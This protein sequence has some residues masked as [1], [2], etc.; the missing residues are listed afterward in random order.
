MSLKTRWKIETN[1][2]IVYPYGLMYILSAVLAI[3]FTVLLV[4]YIKYE[5]AVITDL[6]SLLLVLLFIV[7]LFWGFAGTFV[8]FDNGRGIMQKKL[9]GFVPVST[10]PFNQLHGINVVSN[11]GGGYKY[12]LF[13]K[14]NRYGKGIL[15]S[16]GYSKNNDANAIAFVE[17]VVPVIHSY[18]DQHG[19]LSDN[20]PE[21]I[22]SYQ[23]FTLQDGRYTVKNNPIGSSIFGV[24]FIALGIHELTSDAWLEFNGLVG[25]IFIIGFLLLIGVIFINAA[26]TKIT[27]DRATQTATRNSPIGI[28]NKTYMLQDFTGVQTVR[29]SINFVYAGTEVHMHFK[30]PGATRQQVVVVSAFKKGRHVERF[31]QEL[32]SIIETKS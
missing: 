5:N 25:K 9:F 20:R 17:E 27:F 18:L 31:I 11:V 12:R 1:R 19:I 8:E 23:Y 30:Q 22:T 26:I 3:I 29:K 2:V 32:Y 24:I 15:V 13:L 28:G 7:V 14:D 21:P 16:S 10:I 4:V 6:L